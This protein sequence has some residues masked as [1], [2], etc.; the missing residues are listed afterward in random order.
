[1]KIVKTDIVGE[2][3]GSLTVTKDYTQTGER[4]NRKTKWKCVCECGSELWVDRTAL[5]KR[6]TPYCDKCRPSGR[7]NESLYHIYYGMKQRCYNPNNPRYKN[8]GGK[9]VK[10]CDEWDSD[11][12]AF[13]EWAFQHGYEENKGM[14]IDRLDESK[15]YNPDNCEWVSISENSR[16]GNIGK[17][18]HIHSLEY[19]Y[20]ISPDDKKIEIQN[21]SDFSRKYNLSRSSVSA[22]IHGRLNNPYCGYVFHS[23]LID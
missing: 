14:S 16:R 6:K 8:Y 12:L 15:G 2:K 1:M 11:Y 3:F 17:V 7:R 13:R 5:I 18:K 9:G 21:I 19:I 10:I 22:V 20:A 4:P 23:N